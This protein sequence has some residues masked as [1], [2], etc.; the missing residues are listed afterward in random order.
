MSIFPSLEEVQAIAAPIVAD[1]AVQL[2][3]KCDVHEIVS[4]RQPGG[5]YKDTP[6][7][8]ASDV[9]IRLKMHTTEQAQ[10]IFGKE[11]SVEMRGSCPRSSATI[12][13]GNVIEVVDGEF[14]GKWLRVARLIE[15]PLSDSYLLGFVTNDALR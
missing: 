2:G 3:S 7:L 12:A 1:A 5:S 15:K 13:I 8:A 6:Q 9:S 4:V 14:E 11:T 10:S